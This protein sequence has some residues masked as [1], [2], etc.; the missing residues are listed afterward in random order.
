MKGMDTKESKLF[1]DSACL[2][3]NSSPQ[4][5]C[6]T[7]CDSI[8]YKIYLPKYQHLIKHLET[9]LSAKE[10]D[11]ATKYYKEGD[12]NRFIVC[13]SLLKFVLARHTNSDIKDIILELLPNNKPYLPKDPNIFF[14][15]SHSADY[16]VLAISKNPIGID[17]EHINLSFS[18]EKTLQYIFNMDEIEFINNAEH[19]A[20]TFYSLWTRKE[21]FAKA[22][23][24]GIDD[25]FYK[26]PCQNGLHSLE[27]SYAKNLNWQIH[28]FKIEDD[29]Y[30]GALARPWMNVFES[31]K[32][33]FLNIPPCMDEIMD[34]RF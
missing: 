28:N 13:R 22:L 2:P 8:I 15:L 12:R 4:D 14:N 34:M 29:N 23:G 7:D 18:F 16:A 27:R 11:R 25:N 3:L 6:Y 33:L 9:F 32:L 19:K 31:E 17:I 24:T 5:T 30:I 1:I 26:I 20:Y 21:A 10:Y